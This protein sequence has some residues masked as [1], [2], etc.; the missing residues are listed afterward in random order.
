MPTIEPLDNFQLNT[1]DAEVPLHLD[2][3]D[4]LDPLAL[5]IRETAVE[6]IVDYVSELDEDDDIEFV[7]V[8]TAIQLGEVKDDRDDRVPL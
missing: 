6:A 4:E 1:Y 5:A 7:E 3:F 2:Q 8:E